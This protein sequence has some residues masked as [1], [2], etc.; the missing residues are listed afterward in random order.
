MDESKKE[1]MQLHLSILKEA[2]KNEG[3]IL[4][5]VIDCKDADNSRLA[6]VDKEKY[7][8]TGVADGVFV[9]I[10]DFNEGLL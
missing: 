1:Y 3:L 9:S 7:L 4:W 2:M 6:F 8:K 5:I 10:T